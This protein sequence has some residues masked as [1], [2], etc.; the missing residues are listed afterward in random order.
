MNVEMLDQSYCV[1][2]VLENLLVEKPR[3]AYSMLD[4]PSKLNSIFCAGFNH[5]YDF[6]QDKF[7]EMMSG[8]N[9]RKIAVDRRPFLSKSLRPHRINGGAFCFGDSG[10]P[11]WV[12]DYKNGVKTPV[13]MGVF[14]FMPWGTCTGAHEPSYF[15]NVVKFLDWI[16]Q[17]VPEDQV[18]KSSSSKKFD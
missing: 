3:V 6:R 15:G 7:V 14:S 9:F 5:T 1:Q 17:Y 12:Y 18:C 13:Q 2:E 16:F 8:G 4:D 11:L 10:G